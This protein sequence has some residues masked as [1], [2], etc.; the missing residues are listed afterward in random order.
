MCRGG[1]QTY[2]SIWNLKETILVSSVGG[3]RRAHQWKCRLLHPFSLWSRLTLEQPKWL[4]QCCS[5]TR[6]CTQQS[7][8]SSEETSWRTARQQPEWANAAINEERGKKNR[9]QDRFVNRKSQ[10]LATNR[11]FYFKNFSGNTCAIFNVG[12]SRHT[13]AQRTF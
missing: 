11:I 10:F 6:A 4:S 3:G 5:L 1:R 12:V 9:A 13:L 2:R 7:S 8:H